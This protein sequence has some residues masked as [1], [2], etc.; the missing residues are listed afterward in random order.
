[1]QF[2]KRKIRGRLEGLPLWQN[3]LVFNAERN[4]HHCTA[5][6]LVT[7]T[8]DTKRIE[9]EYAF[10]AHRGGVRVLVV[11]N[12]GRDIGP[13]LSDAKRGAHPSQ[14][15]RA[16][17]KDALAQ[18]TELMGTHARILAIAPELPG[19][20]DAIRELARAGVV[21]ALGHS[22]AD[23]EVCNQAVA[24]GATHVI[25]LFNAMGPVHHRNPGL[26]G[27][28]LGSGDVTAEII[29]DGHHVDRWMVAA[30]WRALGPDRLA[31]VS[32]AI[33]PAGLSLADGASVRLESGL[34][35]VTIRR[36]SARV[37]AG[38]VLPRAENGSGVLAGAVV[39]LADCLRFAV[40]QAGV[41]LFDAVKMA[42]TTP[43]RIAGV[44]DRKGSIAAGRDADLVLLDADLRVSAVWTRGVSVKPASRKSKS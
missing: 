11:A 24:A 31:L 15:L 2:R 17:R 27:F 36:S 41:P 35:R 44:S 37:S 43:A 6:L 8:A 9:I 33:A 19:A 28:T 21:V 10:R 39:S 20:H 14:D 22:Q 18:L 29:A 23:A 7:T 26:A 16:P 32:D 42:A 38:E 5:D 34:G 30:A 1:M 3:G 25:H 4:P 12:R 13:F 40:H